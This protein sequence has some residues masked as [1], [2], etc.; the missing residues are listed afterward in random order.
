MLSTASTTSSVKI[1]RIKRNFDINIL[2]NFDS[3]IA[4][5]TY[6]NMKNHFNCK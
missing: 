3:D 4:I 2:I 1:V 6:R 5:E